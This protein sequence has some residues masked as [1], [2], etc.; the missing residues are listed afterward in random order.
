MVVVALGLVILCRNAVVAKGEVINVYAP[1][2][3]GDVAW[4][5]DLRGALHRAHGDPSP[6]GADGARV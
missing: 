3:E 6:L 4:P 2:G 5:D 1:R